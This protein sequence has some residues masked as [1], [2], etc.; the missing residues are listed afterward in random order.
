MQDAVDESIVDFFE[1]K[2]KSGDNHT[3]RG[4]IRGSD[5]N[6]IFL[7]VDHRDHNY[8]KDNCTNTFFDICFKVNSLPYQVQHKALKY[9]EEFG[10]HSML[11]VNE[12]FNNN[13]NFENSFN[14]DK[15]DYQFR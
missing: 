1:L 15:I 2:S 6:S 9:F 13:S 14:N 4:H 10:L 7:E 12:K 3:L 5:K 8:L 11:I